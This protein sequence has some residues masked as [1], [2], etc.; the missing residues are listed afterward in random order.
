[1]RNST[2][3]LIGIIREAEIS[4]SYISL[5]IQDNWYHPVGTVS[6]TKSLIS[7][8]YCSNSESLWELSVD[9]NYL[10]AVNVERVDQD[11]VDEFKDKLIANVNKG[12]GD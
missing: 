5:L 4:E 9:I 8:F 6:I 7:F 2:K 12:T 3:E 10:K 1:M 11:K